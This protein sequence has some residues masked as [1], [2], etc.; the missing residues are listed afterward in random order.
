MQKFAAALTS[1]PKALS[2]VQDHLSHHFLDPSLQ[3]QIILAVEEAF[4]N[5]V[6]HGYKEE[7]DT[8]I[9]LDFPLAAPNE[10]TIVLVDKAPLFNP[11]VYPIIHNPYLPLEELT[12]GGRGIYLY[13]K[14]MDKVE[15]HNR[16]GC[17][18]LS[19]TKVLIKN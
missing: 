12:E 15:W 11:L 6:K 7:P 8:F 1:L 18:H 9:D 13:S 3:H 4:V 19:L 16:N 5:I 17:N 10:I 14:I 2:Y